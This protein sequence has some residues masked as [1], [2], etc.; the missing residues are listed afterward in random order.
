MA[1]WVTPDSTKTH[2][3]GSIEKM[4]VEIGYTEEYRNIV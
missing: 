3:K 1:K 4:K 2:K